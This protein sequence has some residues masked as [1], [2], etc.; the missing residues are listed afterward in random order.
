MF[1]K[2]MMGA[3]YATL[4]GG[5]VL[6]HQ[7]AITVNV[8][9]KKPDGDH[10]FIVAP[11]TLASWGVRLIP[12]RHLPRLPREAR[13][14]LPAI[15]AGARELERLP[16]FVL[17][18]V[19]SPREHVKVQKRGDCLVIDVDSDDETVHLSVPIRTV[20]DTLAGLAARQ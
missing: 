7:G 10:V 18:E 6:F 8:K 12:E 20:L 15:L 11:A 16:D 2:V 4:I 19:E 3:L 5:A 9:E 17:V 14:S 13:E 1:A